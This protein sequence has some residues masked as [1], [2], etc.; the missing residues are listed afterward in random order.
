MAQVVSKIPELDE[1]SKLIFV[2]DYLRAD[3]LIRQLLSESR[4]ENELL[5]HLRWIEL[6]TKLDT[7]EDLKEIYEKKVSSSLDDTV[8]RIALVLTELHGEF[9]PVKESILRLQ[10]LLASVGKKPAIYYGLGLAME[11]ESNWSRAKYNYEQCVQLDASWYPGYFGLSQIH[12]QL[13]DE[14]RGDHYFFLFE[15]A[16]PYNVYGNFETHKQLADAYLESEEFDYAEQCIRALSEWWVDNKGSCPR[17]IQVFEYLYLSKI[18]YRAGDPQKEQKYED[19]LAKL[20]K[21][22]QGDDRVGDSVLFFVAKVLEDFGRLEDSILF[23]KAILRSDIKN[24]EV[25]QKIG[26]QFFS[27]GEYQLAHEIFLEAY[28]YH[29]DHPEIRFCLL[30]AKLRMNSV[31]V[32]EY[33]ITK[34]RLKSLLESGGD[35]IEVM[36]VLHSLMALYGEDPDIHAQMGEVYARL[37]NDE[38]AGSHF[39]KMYELDSLSILSKLKYV[40]YLLRKEDYEKVKSILEDFPDSS[41]LDDETG[42]EILWVK[43]QYAIYNGNYDQALNALNQTLQIDPWNVAYLVQK[44]VCLHAKF[45]ARI[46]LPFNDKTLLNLSKNIEEDLDW[47]E[48]DDITR[49]LNQQSFFELVYERERLKYLYSDADASVLEHVVIAASRYDAKKGSADLLRLLNTN[50]DGPDIYW[51]LGILYKELWQLETATSWFELML[52]QPKL[53]EAHRAKALLEI[54]DNYVWQACHFDKALE[55]VKIALDFFGVSE[56]KAVRCMAHVCLRLGQVRQAELYI[57]DLGLESDLEITYLKG[58]LH[59]RNGLME[60]AKDTWKPLLTARSDGLRIHH[61]KQEVMRYYFDSPS[62]QGVN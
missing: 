57:E 43:A 40:S 48:Y 25:V 15:E 26:S 55:F 27:M 16:A 20:L 38:R 60:K 37:G 11:M 51:A 58:L 28:N 41:D 7:L 30:V 36:S 9:V 10:A 31:H 17:E 32:E 49:S 56:I 44:I 1:V 21:R 29:P 53:S 59:Y 8:A 52:I 24:P 33:L 2:R 13:G 50:F 39:E 19:K 3:T 61:I 14:S 42:C 46:Q 18:A 23:Y 54:A 35:K 47:F 6:S 12:Y 34:E 4:F 45:D 22:L 5:V 62:Y